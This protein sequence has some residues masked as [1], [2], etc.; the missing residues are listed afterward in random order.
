MGLTFLESMIVNLKS[1]Y[2]FNIFHIT[3]I[4]YFEQN[5]EEIGVKAITSQRMYFVLQKIRCN[6]QG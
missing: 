4:P 1:K 3:L 6:E 5:G 2:K